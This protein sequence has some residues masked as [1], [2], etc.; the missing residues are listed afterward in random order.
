LINNQV[1]RRFDEHR[2]VRWRTRQDRQS[3]IDGVL[4]SIIGMPVPA[5]NAIFNRDHRYALVMGFRDQGRKSKTAF[6][7]K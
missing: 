7:R 3:D 1:A 4:I 2:V 5:V 6:W